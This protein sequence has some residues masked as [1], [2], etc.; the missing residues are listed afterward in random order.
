MAFQA[1]LAREEWLQPADRTVA[2]AQQAGD[3][4]EAVSRRQRIW[5]LVETMRRVHAA[6]EAM[7][8]G[9]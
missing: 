3:G 7:V 1:A 9:V 2:D 6:S 5:P 8:W 4:G